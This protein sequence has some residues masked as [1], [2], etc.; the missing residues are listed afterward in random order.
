MIL[1]VGRRTPS[2]RLDVLY[3]AMKT[4]WQA[5]PNVVLVLAGSPPGLG[6]DPAMWWVADARVKVVN[7]PSEIEK[8]RLLASA[9]VV[10]S[11]SLTE[12]FGITILEAWAQ[13]TPVV[14]TDSPVNRSVVRDG[15]DGLVATG[16]DAADLAA[17]LIRL[18][19]DE[20]MSASLGRAGRLRAEAEFSWSGS[21]GTLEGLMTD[22]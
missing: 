16:P 12:S 17:V 6:P 3:E 19:G 14:V 22:L 10:V 1:F 9:Y 21:A 5:F 7:N 13:S 2:K 18:L 8:D 15:V 20:N 11:P 4:V